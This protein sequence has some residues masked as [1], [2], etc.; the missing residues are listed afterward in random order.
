MISFV[1][2]GPQMVAQPCQSDWSPFDPPLSL[3]HLFMDA[4]REG[5][6]AHWD[7]QMISSQW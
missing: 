2:Q 4:F 7:L 5:W 3:V 1:C 6:G